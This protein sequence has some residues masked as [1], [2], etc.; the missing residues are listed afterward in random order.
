MI[1][2]WEGRPRCSRGSSPR[3]HAILTI[4]CGA[5]R[6]PGIA[7][8]TTWAHVRCLHVDA[9][10]EN[11]ADFMVPDPFHFVVPVPRNDLLFAVRQPG[12]APSAAEYELIDRCVQVRA[13]V[14]TQS[15]SISL[16]GRVDGAGPD[17]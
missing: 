7:L 17:S 1:A 11:Y 9:L 12:A 4:S 5:H 2:S 16:G 8:H 3:R 14:R 13:C 15:Q 6:L 10:Q